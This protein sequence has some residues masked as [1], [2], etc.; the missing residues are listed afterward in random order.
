MTSTNDSESSP[1]EQQW[2][3]SGSLIPRLAVS[4][5]CLS[6]RSRLVARV[7]RKLLR[8]SDGGQLL[9][10]FLW[11]RTKKPGWVPHVRPP[12]AEVRERIKRLSLCLCR[13]PTSNPNGGETQCEPSCCL[14]S[15]GWWQ[16]AQSI[17]SNHP[18]Q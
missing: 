6:G 3:I 17:L 13:V 4:P 11:D 7:P 15:F 14:Y 12:Q 2:R 18:D 1:A 5:E 8:D 16:P 9:G 10:A